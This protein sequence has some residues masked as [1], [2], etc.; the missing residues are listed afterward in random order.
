MHIMFTYSKTCRPRLS[1]RPGSEK[2]G[3]GTCGIMNLIG[4]QFIPKSVI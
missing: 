1:C 2:L 4:I 3:L